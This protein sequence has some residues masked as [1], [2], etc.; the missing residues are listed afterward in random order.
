MNSLIRPW[1]EF[2]V[3]F[4][5][6]PLY[7]DSLFFIP[8]IIIAPQLLPDPNTP[9]GERAAYFHKLLEPIPVELITHGA[10]CY[11]QYTQDSMCPMSMAGDKF[12]DGRLPW[13]RCNGINHIMYYYQT[14]R[15]MPRPCTSTDETWSTLYPLTYS[16]DRQG[17]TLFF[18]PFFRMKWIYNFRWLILLK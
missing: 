13:K 1:Y 8:P 12:A 17:R 11:R 5:Y 14:V 7:K 15:W 9:D 3:H 4:Y 18:S 2:R 10:W 16:Y 6:R